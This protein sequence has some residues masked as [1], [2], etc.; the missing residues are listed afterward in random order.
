[1]RRDA[2]FIIEPFEPA[3]RG[4]S[5]AQLQARAAQAV[6]GLDA[7][8]ACPRQCGVNRMAGEEGFCATGRYARVASAFPHFG[9]EDCLRG[10]HG[11]GTIFFN[12]CNLGC[13]FCQNWDISQN[14][15]GAAYPPDLQADLMIELQ[16]A[17]CHNINFVTP[18]H[19]TAQLLEAIA[20]AS[21]KGLRIPIVYNTSAYDSAETLR[22][23]DGI[24]D[25][26]MP[27]FKCWEPATAAR[28]CRAED[29]PDRARDAIREMHRQVGDL[30]FGQDGVARRGVLVRLLVMP[31]QGRESADIF[32][33]LAA[34]LS[35]DTF[36]NIMAQYRPS[37]RVGIDSA[38]SDID[39]HV[40][41]DELAQAY[42]AARDAGLWRFDREM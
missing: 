38:F 35:P 11:S 25:I 33:W 8:R 4:L 23:F 31:G 39:R 41:R 12:S 36:V 22:F 40:T 17:R 7:C 37:N 5:A 18:S 26:Y 34:E 42:K 1:V 24:V 30:R 28:L 20:S 21:S 3:Y 9:E 27:D 2:D 19:V 10:T 13:V 15:V 6:A 32:Q 16:R 29:Y 14:R